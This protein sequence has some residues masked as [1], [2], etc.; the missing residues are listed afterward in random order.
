MS[1]IKAK[2]V[3]NFDT[4]LNEQTRL[5]K[6]QRNIARMRANCLKHN[7]LKNGIP[8]DKPLPA[9]PTDAQILAAIARN[10]KRVDAAKELKISKAQLYRKL[11]ALG[12]KPVRTYKI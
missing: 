3:K 12:V 8:L 5:Q 10:A 1:V 11:N 6:E 9:K 4:W 7:R 2:Y